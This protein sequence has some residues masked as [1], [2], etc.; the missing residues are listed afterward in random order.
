MRTS[1]LM[2]GS[3]GLDRN[4]L[5]HTKVIGYKSF[6]TKVINDI[7]S[8]MSLNEPGNDSRLTSLAWLE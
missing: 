3:L 8:L 4:R 2:S 7:I 6:I 1:Y 5:E